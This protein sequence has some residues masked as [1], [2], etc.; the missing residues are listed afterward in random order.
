MLPVWLTSGIPV[1]G[2]SP[3]VI[4]KPNDICCNL[5][6]LAKGAEMYAGYDS[7]NTIRIT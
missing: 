6:Q 4:Y 2:P 7:S 1:A 5:Q 3:S